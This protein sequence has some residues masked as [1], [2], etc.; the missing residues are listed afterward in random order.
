M[1]QISLLN[2]AKQAKA[3][4]KPELVKMYV[5]NHKRLMRKK[6]TPVVSRSQ[7]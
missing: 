4:G 6:M 3:D 1:T 5:E 2:L 7:G